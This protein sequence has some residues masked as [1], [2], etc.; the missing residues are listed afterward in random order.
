MILRGM[1]ARAIVPIRELVSRYAREN[2]LELSKSFDVHGPI[3][4][5]PVAQC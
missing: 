5:T 4:A 1:T 3:S 2:P